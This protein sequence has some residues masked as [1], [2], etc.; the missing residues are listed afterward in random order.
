M[1]VWI[2]ALAFVLLAASASA[3]TA[4]TIT[5]PVA[6]STLSGIA[7]TFSWSAGTGA[8]RYYLLV[9]SKLDG[10]DILATGQTIARSAN[11]TGLPTDGRTIYVTLYSITATDQWLL[12]RTT[13]TATGTI[14]PPVVVNGFSKI[15]WEQ[16][17]QTVVQ[18][19][20]GVYRMF[21]DAATTGVVIA[22]R[23]CA[24]VGIVTTCE[25][26]LPALTPGVHTL[27]ITYT[28][29]GGTATPKSNVVSVTT[30]VVLTPASL[31]LK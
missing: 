14:P 26:P 8:T 4:A 13:Y 10:Y 9:G 22:S 5:A 16:P 27:S 31:G 1:K 6:G 28:P 29:A 15:G 30:I 23:T 24:V 2:A 7:V 20:A 21:V 12:V 18:A 3:Q 25:A 17:G 11:V 19:I